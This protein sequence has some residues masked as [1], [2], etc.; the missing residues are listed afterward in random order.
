MTES[1]YMNRLRLLLRDPDRLVWTDEALRQALDDGKREY[2]RR[3]P[4]LVGVFPAFPERDGSFRWPEDFHRFLYAVNV[5]GEEIAPASV[6]RAGERIDET[7]DPELIID[8]GNLEYRFAPNPDLSGF[9]FFEFDP[10]YGT[11]RSDA[12]AGDYIL[13]YDFDGI[14]FLTVEPGI[15]S[16]SE[17]GVARE[18]EDAVF[19]SEYGVEREL[20]AGDPAATIRYFRFADAE[21]W[22]LDTMLGSVYY[23]ASLL[24]EAETDRKDANAAALMMELFNRECNESATRRVRSARAD[25]NGVMF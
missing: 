21:E 15:E 19:N 6:R 16:D 2:C 3:V 14:A 8:G 25:R 12:E 5:A 7:G 24:L 18:W 4:L 10:E 13:W 1:D 17:Y 23:A 22:A 11:V 20:M 9:E